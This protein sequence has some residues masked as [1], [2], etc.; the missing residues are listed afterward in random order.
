L[1]LL[2]VFS[3]LMETARFFKGQLAEMLTNTSR[4]AAEVRARQ[5]DPDHRGLAVKCD[6]LIRSA[7][8]R[9]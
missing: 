1:P 9:R 3:G 4:I 5:I 8:A 7:G 2:L 6:R